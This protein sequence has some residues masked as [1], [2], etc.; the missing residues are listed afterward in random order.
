MFQLYQHVAGVG[1]PVS[2]AQV[3][4]GV[5]KPNTFVTLSIVGSSFKVT[6]YNNVDAETLSLQATVVPNAYGGAGVRWSG[7]TPPGNGNVYSLFRISYPP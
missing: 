7:S 3:L 1:S 4:T 6:A 2:P 5:F